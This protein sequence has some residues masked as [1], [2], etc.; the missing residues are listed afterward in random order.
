MANLI[1]LLETIKDSPRKRVNKK[2]KWKHLSINNSRKKKWA[3][4]ETLL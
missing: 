4:K 3:R 1:E 2:R